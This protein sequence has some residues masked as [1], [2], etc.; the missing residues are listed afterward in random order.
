MKQLNDAK[1]C[2]TR[3][4]TYFSKNY[5]NLTHETRLKVAVNM[6]GRTCFLETNLYP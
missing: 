3:L 5:G 1:G 2:I 4:P 6:E